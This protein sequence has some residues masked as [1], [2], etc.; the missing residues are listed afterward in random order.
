LSCYSGIYCSLATKVVL[1]EKWSWQHRN[2]PIDL[3]LL[4][5]GGV[6]VCFHICRPDISDICTAQEF[7]TIRWRL[8]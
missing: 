3:N 6:G 4:G 2:N 1:H 7:W 5:A 8:W